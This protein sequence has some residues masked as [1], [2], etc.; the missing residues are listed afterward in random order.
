MECVDSV[1]K[2]CFMGEEGFK[3]TKTKQRLETISNLPKLQKSSYEKLQRNEEET[4]FE[5]SEYQ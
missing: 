2:A 3:V 1:G 5:E 4:S